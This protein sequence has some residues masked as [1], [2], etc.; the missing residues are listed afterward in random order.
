MEAELAEGETG[1]TLQI[2]LG[3]SGSLQ[4]E[5][6]VDGGPQPDLAAFA[7]T[8]RRSRSAPRPQGKQLAIR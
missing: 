6:A 7:E 8:V 5:G 1:W 3:E 2:P 4:V